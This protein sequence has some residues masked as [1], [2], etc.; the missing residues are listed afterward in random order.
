MEN[1]YL[2]Q[3]CVTLVPLNTMRKTHLLA[4]LND[5]ED[6]VISPGTDLFNEHKV[7]ESLY[8]LLSGELLLKH[9]D[10]RE[11]IIT[12]DYHWLPVVQFQVEDFKATALTD[13]Y[14]VKFDRDKLDNLLTWS[15]IADYL[16][17]EISYQREHD[18]DLEWMATV[19]NSN[20]FYK[21]PPLNVLSIY[22]KMTSVDVK[23][24]DVILKEG[25]VGDYCYFI[26][27][28]KA[29]VLQYDDLAE[30]MVPLAEIGPGRC[31][32][33][34]ALIKKT[35]RNATVEMMS[36]G[37]LMRITKDDFEVLMAMPKVDHI[38][39]KSYEHF[40]TDKEVVY[41]DI[42]SQ[43]EF[44]YKHI[45]NA[46]HIPLNLLRL[47]VRLLDKEKRY[48]V[49]CNSGRRSF[50]AA[51]LLSQKGYKVS[52]LDSGLRGITEQQANEL[53]VSEYDL[54]HQIAT[55]ESMST[56]IPNQIT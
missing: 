5:I 49:Y 39:I 23:K 48:C 43:E 3:Q 6:I 55:A 1:N 27:T 24:G 36:D 42:R 7:K 45:N 37:T 26:K 9:K 53:L 14:L 20:L 54:Y 28:G 4:A 46:F 47:K 13:C 32:G 38:P 40:E 11:R 51:Y 18:S 22:S 19:L 50:A 25:D 44:D 10:G 33:E 30:E 56:H 41:L 34:D 17:I 35:T 15:Q 21:I 16:D 52:V 8:Y 29:R 31:F 12:A 2:Y